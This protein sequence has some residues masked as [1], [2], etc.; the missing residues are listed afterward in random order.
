MGFPCGSVG[1]ESTC[2]AGDL[3]TIAGLGRSPGGG[4]GYSLQYSSL[5]NSKDCIVHGVTNSQTWLSDFDF[6]TNIE[7][8]SGQVCVPNNETGIVD[9]GYSSAA[10]NTKLSLMSSWRSSIFISEAKEMEGKV[11]SVGVNA[12]VSISKVSWQLIQMIPV[13]QPAFYNNC[14]CSTILKTLNHYFA[15]PKTNIIL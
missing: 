11:L 1:K 4:K 3:G 12:H 10:F 8:D 6:H 5:E 9:L 2:N 14:K 13:I 15:H 7:W